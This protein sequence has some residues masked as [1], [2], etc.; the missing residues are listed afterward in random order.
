MDNVEKWMLAGFIGCIVLLFFI[1][2]ATAKNQE[3]DKLK[4][5]NSCLQDK[6]QYECNVLWA[7]T[8]ESKQ[9]RDLAIGVAAGAAIGAVAGR[10]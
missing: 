6:K 7:Q 1:V 3:E 4:F 9:M 8:D 5:M 2:G 10:K